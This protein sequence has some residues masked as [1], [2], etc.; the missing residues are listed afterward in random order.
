M[1]RAWSRRGQP[2]MALVLVLSG[3]VSARAMMW[4]PEGL[5]SVLT[6]VRSNFAPIEIAAKV[7]KT[8]ASL[9][10]RAERVLTAPAGFANQSDPEQLLA[11]TIA[12]IPLINETPTIVAAF[13]ESPRLVRQI[14]M[15]P[16]SSINLRVPSTIASSHKLLWVTPLSQIPMTA[17]P[18]GLP[19]PAHAAVPLIPGSSQPL[20]TSKLGANTVTHRWSVD[21]WVL[22]RRGSNGAP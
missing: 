16:S 10:D 8:S 1:M 12:P 11:P 19:D 6:P 14:V 18:L 2:L 9:T 17:S 13:S 20:G 3:W 5:P 4:D 22:W 15:P 7:L 21:S